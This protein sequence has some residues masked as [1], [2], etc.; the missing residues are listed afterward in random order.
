MGACNEPGCVSDAVQ[1]S[2]R[3]LEHR[4]LIDTEVMALGDPPPDE[5]DYSEHV[6]CWDCGGDGGRAYCQED[7]CPYEGGEEV[8]DDPACWRRCST[9]K[10]KGGWEHDEDCTA[11][12]EVK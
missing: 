1:G 11:Q 7:C 5:D 6:E 4:D 2:T 10:G 12:A 3:C 8:C 9:C